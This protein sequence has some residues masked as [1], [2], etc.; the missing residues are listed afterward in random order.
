MNSAL[1]GPRGDVADSVNTIS[2]SPAS[3]LRRSRSAATIVVTP[4]ASPAFISTVPRAAPDT[5][6]NER[7]ADA[8]SADTLIKVP[9]CSRT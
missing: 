1:A 7:P 3:G 2:S 8:G 5:A 4:G 9:P 6:R